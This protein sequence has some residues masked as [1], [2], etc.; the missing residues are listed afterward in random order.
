MDQR[1]GLHLL[2]IFLKLSILGFIFSSSAFSATPQIFYDLPKVAAVQNRSYYLNHEFALQLGTLPSDA[3]NKG[4]LLGGV[5][6]YYFSE[7]LG[8][9][10]ANANYSVNAETSLKRDLVDN[11]GAQVQSQGFGGVLD[12]ITY[13]VT[14][15]LVYTPFY[16][17][18]L[19][20][21]RS[22][23]HGELSFIAGAGAA[24]FKNTGI[25]PLVSLGVGLRFFTSPSHSIKLDLR[26][27][28]Y[29]ESSLGAVNALSITAGY[30][31]QLG[32]PPLKPLQIEGENE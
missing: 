10:V 16:T 22:V 2:R 15:N 24:N 32:K 25:K 11:F 7:Y 9:E 13:F 5:Y 4:Y 6:T 21:N 26:N 30:A 1:G 29:F 27:N 3:F 18:S 14:T 20:F 31:W 23:I 12:Y 17:K 8:W 28:V 19:L